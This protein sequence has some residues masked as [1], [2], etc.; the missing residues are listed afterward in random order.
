MIVRIIQSVALAAFLSASLASAQD[1]DA[2]KQMKR[3]VGAWNVV[4]KMFGGPSDAPSVSKGTETK[5]MLGDKWLISHFKGEIMGTS[6]EGLRQ[7]GFDPEK[8]KFV[9]SWVDST[10]RY[11]THAE[12]TWD[13]ETQTMTSI[14]TGKGPS[15]NEMKTKIVVTY[16]EDGSH[17]STM[18]M[19]GQETKMMEFHYTRVADKPGLR[20]TTSPR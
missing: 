11:T 5:F 6:F 3:D 17:T 13:E 16:N 14:G 4:I 18:M 15:G 1:I 7:T 9:A 19:H 10:S 20:S 8:K 12:G 2:A